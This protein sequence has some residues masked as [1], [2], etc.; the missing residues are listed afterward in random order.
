MLWNSQKPSELGLGRS[1]RVEEVVKIAQIVPW[2]C[3]NS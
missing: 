1:N 3:E 2:K